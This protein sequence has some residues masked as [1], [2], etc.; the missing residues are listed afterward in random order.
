MNNKTS[1]VI[2]MENK[3]VREV[4]KLVDNVMEKAKRLDKDWDTLDSINYSD[5]TY[6]LAKERQLPEPDDWVALHNN[7]VKE[8]HAKVEENVN[9]LEKAISQLGRKIE[10]LKNP[11]GEINE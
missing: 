9:E 10:N 8:Y 3:D 5:G 6:R 1:Y 2:S 11:G 7:F 4:N